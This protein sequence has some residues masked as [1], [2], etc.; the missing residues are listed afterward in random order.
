MFESLNGYGMWVIY[1]DFEMTKD[2][3]SVVCMLKIV[4]CGGM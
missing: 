3:V 4:C 1:K 2:I